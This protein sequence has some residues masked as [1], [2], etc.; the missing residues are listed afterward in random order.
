M[1]TT[2]TL[3]LSEQQANTVDAGINGKHQDD[4]QLVGLANGN[5]IALWESNTDEGAGVDEGTDIIG[6]LYNA[7]GNAIGGEFQANDFFA[8][9]ASNHEAAALPNGNFVVVYEDRTIVGAS[10]EYTIR[11]AN[12]G[13]VTSGTIARDRG[14]TGLGDPSVTVNVDGSFLV[15][16]Q[17]RNSEANTTGTLGVIVQSDGITVGEP[18][19]GA[20]DSTEVGTPQ[21]D[22]ATLTNGN[23]VIISRRRARTMAWPCASSHQQE[24]TCSASRTSPTPSPTAT[25]TPHRRSLRSAAAAM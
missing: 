16:Y 5:F 23:Y 4:I 11:D 24:P 8:T 21:V 19:F 17:E 6:Q 13:L 2:P 12:G 14:D 18:I 15:A 22:V 9:D 1:T 3:W 20:A 7:E 10:L 25:M